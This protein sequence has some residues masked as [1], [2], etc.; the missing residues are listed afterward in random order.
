[1]GKTTFLFVA[2]A[3]L[4]L[5]LCTAAV[6]K[7]GT[8]LQDSLVICPKPGDAAN[9]LQIDT[10]INEPGHWGVTERTYSYPEGGFFANPITCILVQDLSSDGKGGS[11][12]TLEGGLNAKRLTIK[13]RSQ[14]GHGLN[15]KIQIYTS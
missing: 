13:L 6:I 3:A 8:E 11:V 4:C 5:Y 12:S 10:N 2:S 7:E 9:K 15:Y 1:M 14:P